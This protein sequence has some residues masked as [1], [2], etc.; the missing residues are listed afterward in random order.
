[1][2]LHLTI[3]LCIRSTHKRIIRTA[4]INNL[5][6][7]VTFDATVVASGPLTYLVGCGIASNDRY[8]VCYLKKRM[9][10]TEATGNA[11]LVM[12]V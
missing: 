5:I 7:I 2:V 8:Q 9:V 3:H 1:M 11:E 6:R 10:L 12:W 4:T